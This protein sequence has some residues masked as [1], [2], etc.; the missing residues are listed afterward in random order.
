MSNF[1][2]HQLTSDSHLLSQPT[3]AL[4]ISIT[5]TNPNHPTHLY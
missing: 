3:S 4:Q 2:I 5:S 1:Q